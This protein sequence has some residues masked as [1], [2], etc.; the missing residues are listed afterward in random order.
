MTTQAE[1]AALLASLRA[2]ATRVYRDVLAQSRSIRDARNAARA[3]ARA[4]AKKVG[5]D[6]DC[7]DLA[8]DDVAEWTKIR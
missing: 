3:Y 7:C 5:L 4:E 2:D 6:D 8:I 1:R